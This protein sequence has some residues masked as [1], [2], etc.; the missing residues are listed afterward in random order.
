MEYSTGGCDGGQYTKD[1]P[2]TN[3]KDRLF[4]LIRQVERRISA[5]YPWRRRWKKLLT[6]HERL[7]TML[8]QRS[9]VLEDENCRLKVKSQ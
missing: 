5:A 3:A 8:H 6:D 7:V 1:E 9:E 2:T 4:Q